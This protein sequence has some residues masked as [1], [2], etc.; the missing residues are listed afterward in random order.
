[1][2]PDLPA[3]A[4]VETNAFFGRNRIKPIHAGPVPAGILPL[5]ARH[6]LNQENT[7][8]AAM[9]CDRKLGFSTFMN[10]PQMSFVKEKDGQALFNDM[11][12]N[13]RRFLP[14]AWF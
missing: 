7:L 3:G 12:E 1:M 4:T 2:I 6:I 9:Q 5:L 8:T 11:L 13:Q 10:D 14:K